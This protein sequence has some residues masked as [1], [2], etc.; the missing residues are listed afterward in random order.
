M[1]YIKEYS[2]VTGNASVTDITASV[3]ETIAESGISNGIAVVEA[4]H[5]TASVLKITDHGKGVIEDIVKEGRLLC[6]GKQHICFAEYDGPR[7]R[8]YSVCVSGE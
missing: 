1:V 6:E 5:S 7:N 4:A 8:T 2:L 3:R